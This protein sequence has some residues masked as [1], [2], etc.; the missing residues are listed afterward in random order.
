MKRGGK[1]IDGVAGALKHRPIDVQDIE[2]D[3]N[4]GPVRGSWEDT[5]LHE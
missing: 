5:V 2:G 3:A 4:M 1:G